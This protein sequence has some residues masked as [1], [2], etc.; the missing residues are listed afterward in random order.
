[1]LANAVGQYSTRQLTDY[2]REQARSHSG[3]RVSGKGINVVEH[4]L[5]R[6]SPPLEFTRF[7]V[8]AGLLA[9]A[10]GQYST[11][12]LTDCFR[13][14]ARSHSGMRVSGKGINVVEHALHR[15]SPPLEFTRFPV[16]AG[17][18]ANAVGQCRTRQLTDCLRK[19][20][21][22][23][24]CVFQARG[25]MLSSMRFTDRHHLLKSH[26]SPV[27][28]GLLANAVGQCS[29]RQ[30]TDCL[31]EQARSHRGMRVSGK[32]IN[33]VE[34]VLHRPSPPLEITRFPV[35]AGLLANAVGQ[36]STRQLTDCFRE[37]AR[38]HSGMRVSGRGINV[39]EPVLHRPSPSLEITRF[40]VGAGLLANAVVQCRTRQLTDCFREQARSHRGMCVSAPR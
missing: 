35:G 28:A 14:Q 4:A 16:G 37:Q 22:T 21:P 19:P 13:E 29:T 1:M 26:S 23:V 24:G 38:S 30:L 27:G 36:C 18:L 11:R 12:Q 40:P 8:G 3:M 32:G 5:H 15:P 34:Y 6:P 17:L 2:F 7:P 25:S 33:V 20:A 31:R 39:V 9:N 10:V